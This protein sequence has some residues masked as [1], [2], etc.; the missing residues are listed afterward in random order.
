M[1]TILIV[2]DEDIAI[3]IVQV[4]LRRA[5]YTTLSATS[6]EAGLELVYGQRPDII[7]LDDMM[8]GIS[9]GEMCAQLKSDP[10]VRD[11]PV[12]MYSAGAKVRNSAYIRQI[13]ADG[14]LFKPALPA[15]ILDTVA[16][17]LEAP[18]G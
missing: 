13:G 1:P 8:P 9:G 4:I 16:A 18:I 10:Q 6:G 11:I 17:Y 3:Q 12:I 15:E 14:V 7:I 2:D 5:G